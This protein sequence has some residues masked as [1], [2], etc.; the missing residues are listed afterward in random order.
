MSAREC[1]NRNIRIVYPVEKKENFYFSLLVPCYIH[2]SHCSL[3]RCRNCIMHASRKERTCCVYSCANNRRWRIILR[4]RVEASWIIILINRGLPLRIMFES[5]LSYSSLKSMCKVSYWCLG[6]QVLT[7]LHHSCS[8]KWC[9][10]RMS[11]VNFFSTSHR[12]T[13]YL[14][15]WLCK[16]G[17]GDV[18]VRRTHYYP[19]YQCEMYLQDCV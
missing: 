16:L 18:E 12:R 17:H 15:G 19:Q 6:G 4:H 8:G 3:N 11:P 5:I 13:Y 2:K 10:M 9:Q 14:W 7:F 1:E